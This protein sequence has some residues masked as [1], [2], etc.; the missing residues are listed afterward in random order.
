[1]ADAQ[2]DQW[3]RLIAFAWTNQGVLDNLREDP[4]K[5]I[6]RLQ[7]LPSTDPDFPGDISN[8]GESGFFTLPPLPEGLEN[9][10]KAELEE[11]LSQNSGI[12]GIM[13][14]CCV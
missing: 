9:L 11:F 2:Q 3:A 6:L 5:E 12:F 7:A 4:K 10:N 8:L 14:F 13:Q 1:M